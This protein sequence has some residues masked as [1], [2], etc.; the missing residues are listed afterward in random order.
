MLSSISSGILACTLPPGEVLRI[1]CS[2]EC[3][4][5]YR[6]RLK[7]TSWALGYSTKIITLSPDNID[8]EDQA[9]NGILI[10]GGADIDPEYYLPHVTSE[11]Q[12]YT[13]RNRHLVKFTEEGKRRDPFEYQLVKSYSEDEKFKNLPMLGICRGMQMMTVAQGI[14]LYLDIKTELGIKN[15]KN[16]FDLVKIGPEDSLMNELHLNESLRGFKIHHQGLRVPYYQANLDKYPKTKVTA[17][18]HNKKIAEALEYTHRPA[19]GVQYH[20]EKSFTQTS[21]PVFRW[22]LK[23][24]CEHKNLS[25]KENL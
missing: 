8:Q 23:K 5:L 10:P 22:F 18:S 12:D 24:A 2:D 3:S 20:P 14:P 9:I 15:R 4:F 21:A 19:L 13:R 16:L 7:T 25:L 1:G 17:Y 6:L 11:L